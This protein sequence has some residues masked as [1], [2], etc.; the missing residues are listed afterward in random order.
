[1]DK[2]N[3][4]IGYNIIYMFEEIIV[5]TNGKPLIKGDFPFVMIRLSN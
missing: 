5:I 2:K 1:M 4:K 3:K